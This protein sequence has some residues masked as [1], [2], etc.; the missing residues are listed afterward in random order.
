MS[1][2][3]ANIKNNPD[4]CPLAKKC[5]GCQ[6][7]NMSYDRQLRWKQAR[8]EIL[9]KKFCKVDKIIGMDEPYHYRYVG[10]VA[11]K[12]IMENGMC[13][14]EFVDHYDYQK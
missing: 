6:L 12:F 10:A 3:P 1:Q 9:L 5:G 14:E 8:V 2:Q 13:L 7:Q 11:A 4:A